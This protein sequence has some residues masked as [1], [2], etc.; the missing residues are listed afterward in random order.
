M[1]AAVMSLRLALQHS[2]MCLKS[3]DVLI[4][5][6]CAATTQSWC[7]RAAGVPSL[8]GPASRKAIDRLECGSV[9]ELPN[10][11]CGELRCVAVHE[12]SLVSGP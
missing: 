7:S 11:C 10:L 8:L 2:R 12:E 3:K 5:H 9:S 4:Q 6:S 1:L